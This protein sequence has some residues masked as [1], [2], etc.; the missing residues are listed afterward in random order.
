MNKLFLVGFVFLSTLVN[1]QLKVT[2]WMSKTGPL[3]PHSAII[4]GDTE[5][6]IVDVQQSKSEALRLIAD[7]LE[8]GK[9]VKW[10]YVTHP[11]LD[12]FAGANYFKIF[13]PKAKFYSI[14][15]ANEEMTYQVKTRRLPLGQGT[16]GGANNLPEEAPN[17]FLT[18]KDNEILKINGQNV[19]IFAGKGDHPLSSIVWVPSAKTII[20]GDVI[21]NQIHAFFGDHNDID[22]WIK[23]VER[24]NEKK[25]EVVVAAHS[26]TANPSGTIVEEQ[27]QWLKDLKKAMGE[28]DTWQYVKSELTKKYPT[29]G[30]DF[31]FE[32]SY[33]V[34]KK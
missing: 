14:Q 21:F 13:F 4:E 34:R 27:L 12:H 26:K 10:I 7:V 5:I 30:N 25:P 1:A 28:N 18:V 20:A 24:A 11:H 8:K 29:W 6:G 9:E 19:E 17:Y 16:P 2:D 3:F 23:L 22:A 32:F 33:G 15:G 31:I